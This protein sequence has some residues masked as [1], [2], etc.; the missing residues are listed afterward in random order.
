M[1]FLHN[2]LGI[3]TLY[4]YQKLTLTKDI[5]KPYCIELKEGT[6][7]KQNIDMTIHIVTYG[8]REPAG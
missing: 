2:I 4:K 1:W 3:K 8:Q 7:T 6:P 5:I